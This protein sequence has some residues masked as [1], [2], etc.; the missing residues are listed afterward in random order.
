MTDQPP[1]LGAD[2]R[3]LMARWATGV[4]VVTSRGPEG[5]AGLT[6]NALLSV[7]LDPPT[8][9]ISLTT[10]ADSTPVIEE[11]RLFAVNLL[12]AEQRALSERFALAVPALDKFRNLSVHRGATGVPLL[13]G[14]LGA[15]E[16]RVTSIIP[17]GDHHLFLGEVVRVEVGPDQLPLLFFRRGYA[18]ATGAD[19]LKL[20]PAGEGPVPSPR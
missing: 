4:S 16:C 6:V 7:S 3:R 17:A 5:D 11:S 12:A 9:L 10:S 8:L 1:P 2:F 18:E 14:A 15:I 13:D 19:G 20:P